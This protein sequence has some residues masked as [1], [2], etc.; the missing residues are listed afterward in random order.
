MTKEMT[1]ELSKRSE[2]IVVLGLLGT[3]ALASAAYFLAVTSPGH[4]WQLALAGLLWMAAVLS[5]TPIMCYVAEQKWGV[6]K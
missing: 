4:S 3:A 2:R 6:K 5:L 1:K